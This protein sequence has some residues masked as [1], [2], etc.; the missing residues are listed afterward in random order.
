M[1]GEHCRGIG[2]SG[3][4]FDL[5]NAT[6]DVLTEHPDYRFQLGE[7]VDDSWSHYFSTLFPY[8]NGMAQIE[9]RTTQL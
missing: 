8:A 6:A 5:R 3:D 1:V 2:W 9:R 7:K 4:E